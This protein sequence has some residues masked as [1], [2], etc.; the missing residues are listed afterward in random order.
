VLLVL[1][2]V[3]KYTICF[4]LVFHILLVLVFSSHKLLTRFPNIL[5]LA[6]SA[7]NTVNNIFTF[8]FNFSGF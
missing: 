6:C 8:F 1:F 3:L 5:L 2:A 7:S 4:Y